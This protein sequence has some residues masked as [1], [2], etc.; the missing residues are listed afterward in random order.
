M[1]GALGRSWDGGVRESFGPP[2]CSDRPGHRR[3]ECGDPSAQAAGSRGPEPKR[4]AQGRICTPGLGGEQK[5][6]GCLLE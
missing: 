3:R 5:L 2:L 6:P 1:T 4:E